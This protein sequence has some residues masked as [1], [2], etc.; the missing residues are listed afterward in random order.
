MKL[1]PL[2]FISYVC[3][4]G[5][6]IKDIDRFASGDKYMLIESTAER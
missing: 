3:L 6:K 4:V 5:V 2:L 1:F